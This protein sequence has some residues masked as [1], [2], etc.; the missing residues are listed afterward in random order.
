MGAGICRQPVEIRLFGGN[1]QSVGMAG[2][3]FFQLDRQAVP[4]RAFWPQLVEQLFGAINV[5]DSISLLENMRLQLR[6]T[7]FSVNNLVLL[8]D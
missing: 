5:A 8:E 3:Q 6:E 4:Q 1:S 2:P 7:S